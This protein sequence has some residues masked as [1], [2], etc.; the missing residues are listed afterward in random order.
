MN[1]YIRQ[2][3]AQGENQHLDFKYEISDARKIAR[4]FSAFANTGGGKLLIGVK[5]DGTIN[6]ITMDEEAYML[7][8]AANQFCKPPV[9]Y[10]AK[11]W[12]VD[13]KIILEV[14]IEESINKPHLSPWKNDLWRAYIRL[15]DENFIANSVQVEVWKKL[16]QG[17]PALIKYQ[18]N[19][20]LLLSFLRQ[21]EEIT[22]KK[23]CKL[24]SIKYPVAKRI[25]INLIVIGII[26]IHYTEN[27][28]TYRLKEFPDQELTF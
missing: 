17:K 18:K 7:E 21:N 22:L 24:A 14:S 12:V 9:E 25:L 5:D 26:E 1:Q 3:I 4:T 20:N 8:S 23:F 6:G 11:S 15:H 28:T 10:T 19:E 16:S 2:L 13:G 27:S